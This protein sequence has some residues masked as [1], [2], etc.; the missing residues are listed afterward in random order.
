MKTIHILFGICALAAAFT[1]CGQRVTVVSPDTAINLSGRWNDEDSKTVSS[2]MIESALHSPW[3]TNFRERTGRAPIVRVTQI[4]NRSNE[5][6]ATGIFTDDLERAFVN[7]GKVR[8]V[9]SRS[10]AEM[11]RA[12]RSDIQT[13]SSK[14]APQSQQEQAPD[15]LLQGSIKVQHDRHGDEEA[16]FYQVDLKLV[17]ATTN[18]LIWPG[19][20]E[21]KKVVQK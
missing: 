4:V 7:S 20:T 8:V 16:K 19:S 11:V 1:G 15:F 10:E 21:R 3:I 9:A 6:I 2:E 17:D 14:D 18:E 13:N 5:E 12:E